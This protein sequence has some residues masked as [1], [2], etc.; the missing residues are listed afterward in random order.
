MKTRANI[1]MIYFLMFMSVLNVISCAKLFGPSD[2]EVI[3]AINNTGLFSGGSEKFSLKS[4]I[5]ILERGS[6]TSDG[7]WPVTVRMT[8]TFTMPGQQES[9]PMVRTSIFYFH[10]SK[11]S[12]GKTTWIAK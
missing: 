1:L 12:S 6:R 8:V 10:K 4:P 11:D 2:E 7:S 9:K 5:E 3:Q